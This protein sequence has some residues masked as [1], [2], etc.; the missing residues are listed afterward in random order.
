METITKE[1]NLVAI[2]GAG[3]AGL[4]A[5]KQLANAGAHIAIFNRDVKPGGLAEY[6]IYPDKYKM[7]EGLRNQ[8][9]QIL[10]L[11]QIDY[12][13]NVKV[14]QTGDLTLDDLRA[15][16]FQAFLITVGAQGTKWLGLPGEDLH[17]VYHAK[18]VVYHYNQLPPSASSPLT[19][20]G[21][22]RSWAPAT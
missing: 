6:G 13:G 22:S 5:S 20:G 12:Y 21:A 18:D 9:R 16:G 7:K 19:S 15:L 10:A 1:K 3:P 4:Y 17:G 8:F 2:I 14:G 11:P